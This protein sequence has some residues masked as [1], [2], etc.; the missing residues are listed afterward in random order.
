MRPGEELVA[1]GVLSH[2]VP[3]EALYERD[4]AEQHALR[5]LLGRR[6]YA[7]LDEV[8]AEGE[9]KGRAAA[10]ARAVLGVLA[11]RGLAPSDEVRAR[12]LGCTD[13]AT[14]ERWVG[15][16]AVESTAE[17]AVGG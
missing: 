9:A 2:P 5:N 8:R 7:S 11:A 14:L 13:E 10:L 12:I 3:V 4:R 6:G 17:A 1:P 15:R 16:A